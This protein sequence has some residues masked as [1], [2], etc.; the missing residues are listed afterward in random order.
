MRS[1]SPLLHLSN[2]KHAVS[3]T[4]STEQSPSRETYS[5]ATCRTMNRVHTLSPCFFEVTETECVPI[6]KTKRLILFREITALCCKNHM[7]YTDI[8]CLCVFSFRCYTS[9]RRQ[10][11]HYT[12]IASN[13]SWMKRK[14]LWPASRHLHGTT[15]DGLRNSVKLSRVKDL[16]H[17]SEE[18]YIF[19]VL[20]QA[21]HY[22]E[23]YSAE[24]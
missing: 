24:E 22:S 11:P 9:W 19:C 17:T 12:C 16:P 10:Q 14:P 7:K 8:S 23:N 3:L 4:N 5:H 15:E 13:G 18:R 6:T 20:K 2:E 1:I 21:V